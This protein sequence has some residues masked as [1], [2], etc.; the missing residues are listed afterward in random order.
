MFPDAGAR[1]C[2]MLVREGGVKVLLALINQPN[3]SS[4]RP[5]VASLAAEVMQIV[6]SVTGAVDSASRDFE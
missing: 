2:P 6:T 1:Y 5:L 4:E 3:L